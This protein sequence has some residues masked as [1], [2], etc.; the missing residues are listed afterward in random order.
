MSSLTELVDR[1]AGRKKPVTVEQTTIVEPP[2]LTPLANFLDGFSG[3]RTSVLLRTNEDGE[4]ER[5]VRVSKDVLT[6]MLIAKNNGSLMP[7]TRTVTH[8][9]TDDDIARTNNWL[10][11]YDRWRNSRSY[12]TGVKRPNPVIIKLNLL[13]IARTLEAQP[14]QKVL[15]EA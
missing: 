4:E 14:P 15:F 11:E 9:A 13:Q 10:E 1:L 7:Q 5:V 12:V 6:G 2:T 3:V 8:L